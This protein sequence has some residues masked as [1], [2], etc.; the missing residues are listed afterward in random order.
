MAE[1]VDDL[2]CLLLPVTDTRLLL[3]NTAVAEVVGY[4][5]VRAADSGPSWLVGDVAWEERRVPLL[6]YEAACGDMAP[7][8]SPRSRV[9][10][11][12][13][14]GER[15][16]YDYLGVVT[17]GHPHLVRVE[18]SIVE[19]LGSAASE[20]TATLCHIKVGGAPAVIPDLVYLEK[21]LAEHVPETEEQGVSQTQDGERP[22]TEEKPPI[23]ENVEFQDE[24]DEGQDD[25]QGG[26]GTS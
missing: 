17:Q 12:Y 26:P 19:L 9:A 14:I 5:S 2:Y 23:E 15:L 18:R 4:S 3:P 24:M 25:T 6:S 13:N 1:T 22:E 21:L 8:P 11:C 20:D 10:L 16:H 7:E